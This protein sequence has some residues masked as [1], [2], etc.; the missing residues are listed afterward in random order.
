MAK[1]GLMASTS[2]FAHLLGLGG[3][4]A[5]KTKA[6][7]EEERTKREEQEREDAK[8]AGK[9]G[10]QPKAEDRPD[11]QGENESDEDY[12]ERK[13]KEQEEAD[14]EEDEEDEKD[15]KKKAVRMRE[16]ARCSA[17][18]AS[19]AAGVRPDLAAHFAFA[20]NLSGRVAAATLE[21]AAQGGAAP[22]K[23]TLADRMDRQPAP[24]IGPEGGSA[25]LKPHQRI[26]ASFAMTQKPPKA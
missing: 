10:G 14:D 26:L 25:E 2:T 13:R 16:R 5:G 4:N 6:E 11:D 19:P 1:S 22:R 18:F 15:A 7:T 3:A 12:K 21:V 8:N 9:G 24:K 20:T 23:G 17:I